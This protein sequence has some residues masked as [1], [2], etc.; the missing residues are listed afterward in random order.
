MAKTITIILIV[1]TFSVVY[2]QENDSIVKNGIDNPNLLGLH[3]FGIFS[4]R[5]VSNF[6]K[7]APKHSSININYSSGNIFH[8]FVEAYFPEDPETRKKQNEV[9]WYHRNFRFVDQ[10]TTPAEYMN[11]LVDAV[12]KEFKLNVTIPISNNQEV[13][14]ALRTHVF[15]KGKYPFSIFTSD[16]FIEWTHSYIIGKEDPYGRRYYG[17]NKTNFEYLDRHGKTV[18]L[19]N[20]D[21]LI[22]GLEF[23][24]YIYPEL[25]WNK[26]HNIYLNFGT[27]LGVNTSKYNNSLDIG[28]SANGLK[29]IPLKNNYRFDIGIGFNLLRKNIINFKSPVDFGNNAYLGTG[30]GDLEITKFTRKNTYHAFGV[31]YQIQSRYNKKE[32]AS[33][34]QL[35]GKWQE[36]RGGWHHGVSTLYKTLS[37]WSFIYTYGRNNLK[38]SIYL[39]EDLLVNN[40]PDLQTGINLK[41]P[42]FNL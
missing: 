27:H 4:S 38:L 2:A 19:H 5:L 1:F 21:F 22:N 30:E 18:D 31:N 14:I 33:Y 39:K 12:I 41:W 11:I 25:N 16:E 6:K 40:A 42:I 35:F 37:Y 34:Y 28:F 26:K 23:S 13:N 17:L 29:T 9:I 15:S 20:N 7:Q 3:H 10:E 24:H 8:P 36:I 32:E